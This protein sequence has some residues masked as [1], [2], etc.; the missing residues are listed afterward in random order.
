MENILNDIQVERDRQRSLSHGGDT[1]TFD[2]TNS[3]NDWIAYLAA[4]SGRAADKVFRNA[5]EKQDFRENM[6]KVAALAVAAIEAYDDG[7]C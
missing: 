4:Y 2:K 1:D 5:R 7:L 6:V 3:R